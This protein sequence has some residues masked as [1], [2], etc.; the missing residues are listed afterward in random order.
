MFER[1]VRVIQNK[2]PSEAVTVLKL[3][4][5]VVPVCP[6]L[7]RDAEVIFK[8]LPGNDWALSDECRSIGPISAA[9]EQTM[10][11]LCTIR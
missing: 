2:R 11:V 9:L 3:V 10:P 4:M 6:C 7:S 8:R 5:R 1:I